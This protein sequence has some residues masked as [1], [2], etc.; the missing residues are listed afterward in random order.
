MGDDKPVLLC[1][2]GS[3]EAHRAIAAAAALLGPRRAVVVDIG[4]TLTALQSYAEVFAPLTPSFAEENSELALEQ[5]KEGLEQAQRAGFEAVAHGDAAQTTWEGI[6]EYADELDAAVI[7]V[8]SHSW[9]AGGE[10]LHGSVSHQ[11][12]VHAQRPVLIVPPPPD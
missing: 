3:N 1:Y 2:D 5:A 12:A 8:G 10:F 7:V 4:P 9:G 11:V 6:V